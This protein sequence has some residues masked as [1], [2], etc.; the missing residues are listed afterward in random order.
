MG[1]LEYVRYAILNTFQDEAYLSLSLAQAFWHPN[2]YCTE[3]TF[4]SCRHLSA[5]LLP[6]S[7]LCKSCR[8][9]S[10]VWSALQLCILLHRKDW[11]ATGRR[12][13]GKVIQL[14]Y[15]VGIFNCRLKQSLQNI[16]REERQGDENESP[17]TGLVQTFLLQYSQGLHTELQKFWDF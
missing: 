12:L 16:P 10:C 14:Q 5:S 2:L 6:W 8:G 11:E 3:E 9:M 7:W 13:P 1:H 4:S 17:T 15:T